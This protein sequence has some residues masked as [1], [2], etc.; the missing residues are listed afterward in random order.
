MTQKS[1]GFS[2]LIARQHIV[3]T[4]E[5]EL[6]KNTPHAYFANYFLT[7][8]CHKVLATGPMPS[9]W[10][11]AKVSH[12]KLRLNILLTA[13]TKF[14][15]TIID[16][17]DFLLLTFRHVFLS[18]MILNCATKPSC[19][20]TPR[21]WR[22]NSARSNCAAPLRRNA[23]PHYASYAQMPITGTCVQTYSC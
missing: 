1:T 6:S 18:E 16:T 11:D 5:E 17:S 2:R 7:T 4:H 9:D 22:M 10:L 8:R 20:N 23:A 3:S 15:C 21:L 14:L 12:A 19:P 13:R